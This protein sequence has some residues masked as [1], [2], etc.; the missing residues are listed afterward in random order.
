MNALLEQVSKLPTE[1][2]LTFFRLA[3]EQMTL[4]EVNQLVKGLETAW[5][6]E[7][8]PKMPDWSNNAPKETEAVEEQTEF[9]VIVVD[10]GP[11]RINVVKAA[12]KGAALE[13][14]AASDLLKQLPA[15]VMAKASKEKAEELKK[16]LEEAGAKVELK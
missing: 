12:R 5:D 2:K 4:G 13:L 8:T 10:N 15:T 14:K 1:E 16:L 7:A 3:A 9:D 6:V 11:K